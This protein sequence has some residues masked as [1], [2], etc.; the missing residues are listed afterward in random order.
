MML[1]FPTEIC[2]VMLELYGGK[3]KEKDKVD[4]SDHSADSSN[5]SSPAGYSPSTK[6]R[7]LKLAH[8]KTY[9]TKYIN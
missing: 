4:A 3:K 6:K 2:D 7:V 8:Q 9:K 5:T 1:L